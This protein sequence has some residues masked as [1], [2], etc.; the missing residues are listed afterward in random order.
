M[1]GYDLPAAEAAPILAQYGITPDFELPIEGMNIVY[2]GQAAVILQGDY[3]MPFSLTRPDGIHFVHV[4][5]PDEQPDVPEPKLMDTLIKLAG[6]GIA[7]YLIVGV[8][9][10]FKKSG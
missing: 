4:A 3:Y 6:W 5:G 2:K 10:A 9:G 8:L 7:A 1:S